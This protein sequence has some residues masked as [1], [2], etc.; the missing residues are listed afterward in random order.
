M[1]NFYNKLRIL[2]TRLNLFYTCAFVGVWYFYLKV[3]WST[4][5]SKGKVN[6]SSNC[7]SVN[8]FL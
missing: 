1:T 3:V 6:S 5:C 8:I 4:V 2:Q 7:I